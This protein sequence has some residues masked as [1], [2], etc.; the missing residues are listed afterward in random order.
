M[1]ELEC[2]CGRKYLLEDSMAGRRG[3][4]RQCGAT[5]DVPRKGITKTCPFCDKEIPLGDAKCEH[6]GEWLN[7]QYSTDSSDL[8]D[9]GF[10]FRLVSR[11]RGLFKNS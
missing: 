10:T 5:L 2:S 6:C 4:C 8:S 1:I 7:R 9:S 11:L 3:T